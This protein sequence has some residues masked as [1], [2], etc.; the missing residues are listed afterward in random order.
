M[1][2]AQ[3][4]AL[5]EWKSSPMRKPLIIRGA[6]QVGKSYLVEM[7]GKEYFENI[8]IINFEFD[9][10]YLKSFETLDPFHIVN[11]LSLSTGQA[12][13]PG[14]TLLFLDE[15][16]E[17]PNAILALRYFKELMP[18]QH[19][20]A[21]GSLLEFTLNKAE[22]RMPVGRVQ[23]LYLKPLSFQEYLSASGRT[24]LVEYLNTV[25]LITGID[26]AIH[27][28]LLEII[29]E[30]LT[31]GGM[32]EV[33]HHYFRDRNLKQVQI[34]QG[35]LLEFYRRDF[36]K[37]DSVKPEYLQ[38]IFDKAPGLIG[39]K[40]KYVKV[41]PEIQSRELKPALKA[42]TDAGLIYPIY[43]TSG[44]GLPF[45][46]TQQESKFKLLFLDVGLVN[47][48]SGLQAEILLQKDL[49]LL[50]RGAI[51]EQ[52]VGQELL[53]YAESYTQSQL[54]YWER[55]KRGSTAEVD[56]LTS[57]QQ[58]IVPIEVKAGKTG[59]LKSLQLFL[60]ERDLNLGVRI[61]Q[62]TFALEQ[63]VLSIPLYMVGQLPR[64]IM[65]SV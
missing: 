57:V 58:H 2:R 43:Q 64:L 14:K 41:D 29:R 1:R 33:V 28:S 36:G 15:I 12:I 51:A 20:I 38:A 35:S 32:P 60:N 18:D 22:F 42:L 5:L 34:L 17:C 31:I 45:S 46:T 21:A 61:S 44:S 59:T 9:R 55:E 4:A 11:S 6:R 13:T 27:E 54:Y 26:Q 47:F 49:L 16:Q 30:Y 25:S 37:Y 63:R 50:N 62:Q 39:Q 52:F 40:F 7:F 8:V 48:T 24:D 10:K 56:Y 65:E 23:S 19:V 53:A 3:L